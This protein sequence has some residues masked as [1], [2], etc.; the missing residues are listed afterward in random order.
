MMVSIAPV[1]GVKQILSICTLEAHD[2]DATFVHKTTRQESRRMYLV[3][4]FSLDAVRV[5]NF[6]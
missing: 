3:G 4:I 5:S 6:P 1:H 2:L